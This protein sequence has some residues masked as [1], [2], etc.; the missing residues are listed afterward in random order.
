MLKKRL[1][2]AL[3]VVVSAALI[4]FV[5]GKVDLEAARGRLADVA[6]GMLV[7]TGALFL[8]QIVIGARRWHV[9]LRGI[10]SP[11]SFWQALRFYYIGAF[12]NQALPSSVGGD[13]VRIY[14]AYKAGMSVVS[15]VNGVMLERVATIAALFLLLLAVQPFFL[16]KVDAETGRWFLFSTA[17]LL[18]A[19]IAGTGVLML[20]DRLPERLRHLPLVQSLATVASDTRRVF[21]RPVTALR[22]L[23]WSALGHANLTV[24]VY[25][26]ALGLD[27]SVTLVDC[28]A[29]FLPVMAVMTLPISIAG[30]GVR[31]GAMVAAFSLIGVPA[32]G[33]LVL[34]LLFGLIAI[35]T[36]LPGGALW[37]MSGDRRVS[38]ALESDGEKPA[39]PASGVSR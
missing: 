25:V 27:L 11:L 15:A 28:F 9:V 16:P 8:L 31:E 10:E 17:A 32:E 3:K 20:L 4:W 2:L 21:L 1:A 14:K 19:V 29:L 26:L 7:L 34:S 33:A 24:A 35:V 30:W 36:T 6:P 39:S 22:A 38:V 23:A 13:A 5:L 37:L 12:F 18:I